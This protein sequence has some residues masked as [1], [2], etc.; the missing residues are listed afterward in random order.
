MLIKR[1][2]VQPIRIVLLLLM[3]AALA[4]TACTPNVNPTSILERPLPDI[5]VISSFFGDVLGRQHSET[6]VS[7]PVKTTLTV[8]L[9][10]PLTGSLAGY[11]ARQKAAVNLAVEDVNSAGG[12]NGTALEVVILDD[13]ADS[14]EASILVRRL[15]EEDKVLAVVGPFSNS[16]FE[17]A[18]HIAGVLAIPLVTASATKPGVT[19]QN[20]PW[21]FRFS[22]V[23]SVAT[24]KAIEAFRKLYPN[25]RRIVLAGDTRD[26]VSEYRVKTL[27]TAAVKAAGL[28]VIGMVPFE[29]GTSNYDGIVA[30]IK[31]LGPDG[32]AY[33]SSTAEAI[34]IAKELQRQGVKAPVIASFQNWQGPEIVLGGDVMDGWITAGTFDE[35]AQDP[36]A[37]SYLGRFAAAAEADPMIIKP[38][39][40]GVATQAYDTIMALAEVMRQTRVLPDTDIKQAR[41][42]I[43]QGLQ[44]LKDFKGLTGQVSMLPGGDITFNPLPFV[45]RGGKWILVK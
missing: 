3:A 10:V 2:R 37:Q 38:V 4:S 21:V 5:S 28:E 29:T 13:A 9:V 19:E 44:G 24:S 42:A 26:S 34:G 11:G 25:A 43:Q 15:A 31:A 41:L 16:G 12:I 23:E 14:Q 18:A 1:L 17:A 39:Y 36:G 8:G 30:Q 27:Y 45:A 20:R 22:L 7:T 40:S 32:I 35:D 6:A 33:S